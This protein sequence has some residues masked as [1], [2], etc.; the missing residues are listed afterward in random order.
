MSTTTNGSDEL[1]ED[2]TPAGRIDWALWRRLLTHVRP[3]RGKLVR[4]VVAGIVLAG[5]DI[6][7]PLLTGA[8][9]DRATIGG[10]AFA[11]C[12]PV[13]RNVVTFAFLIGRSSARG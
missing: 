4:L 11:R 5:L 9:I 12:L 10:G 6:G 1:E 8:L 13:R 7:F 2:A 3:Y